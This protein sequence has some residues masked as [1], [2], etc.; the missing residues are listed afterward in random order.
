MRAEKWL[1]LETQRCLNLMGE[2]DHTIV[3]NDNHY[4]KINTI[5]MFIV[6]LRT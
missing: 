3:E 1:K 6:F 5:L 4:V 2:H